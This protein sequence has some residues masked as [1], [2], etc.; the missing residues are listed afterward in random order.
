MSEIKRTDFPCKRKDERLTRLSF[1][2][3]KSYPKEITIT[4]VRKYPNVYDGDAA[5][6]QPEV[7]LS[8]PIH[9]ISIDELDQFSR[10]WNGIITFRT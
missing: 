9:N 10:L 6:L 3:D 7:R 5:E 8:L 2:T 4:I 1:V